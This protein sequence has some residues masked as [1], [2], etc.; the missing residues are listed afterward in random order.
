MPVL[1]TG[2]LW[3][4]PLRERFFV[5]RE[6]ILPGNRGGGKGVKM[7]NAQFSILN[8]QVRKQAWEGRMVCWWRGKYFA[9][10]KRRRKVELKFSIS[11]KAGSVYAGGCCYC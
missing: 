6:D 4:L 11:M 5:C 10:E 9:G 8:F 3:A 2:I 7:F 1:K